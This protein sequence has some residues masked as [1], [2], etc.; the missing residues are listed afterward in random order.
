MKKTSLKTKKIQENSCQKKQLSWKNGRNDFRFRINQ[1]RNLIL[2]WF[3]RINS[4]SKHKLNHNFQKRL[5][6]KNRTITFS[7]QNAT[8]LKVELFSKF[9]FQFHFRIN[10]IRTSRLNIFPEINPIE[11]LTFGSISN[12]KP[13]QNLIFA[14]A[15]TLKYFFKFQFSNP[16]IK[17]QNWVIF[18]SNNNS[19]NL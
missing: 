3:F 11:K 9:T 19:F 5:N 10:S 8:I 16:F 6:S 2:V 13:I 15:P 12:L 14:I 18:S 17:F 7:Q 4:K 1:N